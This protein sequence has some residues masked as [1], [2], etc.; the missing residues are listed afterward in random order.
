MQKLSR[1]KFVGLVTVGGASTLVGAGIAVAEARPLD[2]SFKRD[3]EP[4]VELSFPAGWFVRDQLIENLRSPQQVLV[5]SNVSLPS[6]PNP[7]E[8]ALPDL[9]ALGDADILLM[10]LAEPL[11]PD[12]QHAR[13][14]PGARIVLDDFQV[15]DDSYPS[16][17]WWHQ[18][19]E[20]AR[21]VY[22]V[23]LWAG[24]RAD[25]ASAR[26]VVESLR[27]P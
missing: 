8:G 25:E 7:D 4:Q 3:R 9:S 13:R 24:Y 5:L 18:W 16:V 21:F 15:R 14:L 12:T 26:A 11:I 23:G 10:V 17:R 19:F 2:R 20:G 27:L 1:E 6:D 22:T